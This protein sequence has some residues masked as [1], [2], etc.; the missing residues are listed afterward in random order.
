MS[1]CIRPL[2]CLHRPVFL[3]NSRFHL[4]TAASKRSESKSHHEQRRPFSRSYGAILPS[5]FSMVL[6][7]TLGYSPRLPVSVCGTVV[8]KISLEGFLGSHSASTIFPK[9]SS[10]HQSHSM[11]SGFAYYTSYADNV[12]SIS[13]YALAP[14]SLHHSYKRL[15]NINLIPIDYAF[16]PRL[17]GRLTL[18][19]LALRRK[20]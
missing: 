2:T 15:R 6:P 18:R 5:S 4:F 14:A 13:A 8:Y 19:R 1:V 10:T 9:E 3:V 20:P 16:Q 7:S 12:T 17:R 11:Y